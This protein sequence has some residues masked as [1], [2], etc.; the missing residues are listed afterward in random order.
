MEQQKKVNILQKQK[1]GSDDEIRKTTEEAEAISKQI[2]DRKALAASSVQ[3]AAELAGRF[4]ENVAGADAIL[5]RI[6]DWKT[7]WKANHGEFMEKFEASAR[8]YE[9][10]CANAE[11]TR[12]NIL[13]TKSAYGSAMSCKA[14]ISALRPEWGNLAPLPPA[15]AEGLPERWNKLFADVQSLHDEQLKAAGELDKLRNESGIGDEKGLMEASSA[16]AAKTSAIRAAYDECKAMQG[17]DMEKLS[18]DDTQRERL[19]KAVAEAEKARIG[20]EQWHK[21]YEIF[22]SSDGKKFRN[23]AQSYVLRQLL[24]GANEYLRQLTDRYELEAQPGSLTILLKDKE[25]GGVLR[26]T[27]TIS[28]GESFLTSLALA[29]GL[30]SLG[31]RAASMDILFIDEGFGTLD[32]TYLETV[33]DALERLHQMGGRKVGIISHVESLKER[34]ATQV[35]VVR[36]SS[37]LSRIEIKNTL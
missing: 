25:A 26:P 5:G 1:D 31:S 29:L 17:A 11:K 34:L 19:G 10:E 15:K 22:G 28:G 14:E 18:N 33:M 6:S 21:L 4:E 37:T 3:A 12:N 27:S 36:V 23:I 20:Y 16:I 8:K 32:G 9:E 24:A 35:R 2:A 13:L 30:S 7:L